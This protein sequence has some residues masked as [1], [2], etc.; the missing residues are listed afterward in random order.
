MRNKHLLLFAP[1][2]FCAALSCQAQ[3]QPAAELRIASVNDQLASGKKSVSAV[4][5]DTSL[6]ALHPVT[7]F[8]EAVKAHAKAEKIRITAPAE[9]GVATSVQVMIVDAA[10]RPVPDALI[11]VYQTDGRGWYSDTAAHVNVREGD[12]GHARLF[13]YLRTDEKGGFEL[14]TIRP[15]SYPNSSLPQHIHLEVFTRDDRV[16]ITE[17]LFDDDPKLVG[18]TRRQSEGAGFY[19]AQNTG[20]P[21]KQL[22]RYRV[23][24]R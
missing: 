23:T 11:Y 19:I 6:R 13:G 12:R 3:K 2:L 21:E 4:L 18:E 7:A 1:A 14:E 10:G 24:L 16:L 17:L 8:R 20:T 5:T 9:P 22:F 15:H